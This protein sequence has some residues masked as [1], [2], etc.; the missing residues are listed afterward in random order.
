MQRR[1]F[2]SCMAGEAVGLIPGSGLIDIYHLFTGDLASFVESQAWGAVADALVDLVDLLID[3]G[4]NSSVAGIVG[5]L[6]VGATN[7][8]FFE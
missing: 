2:V 5:Q 1:D 4:V 6:G 8:A 3:V 7:C